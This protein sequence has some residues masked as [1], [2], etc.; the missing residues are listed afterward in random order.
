[1]EPAT[2]ARIVTPIDAATAADDGGGFTSITKETAKNQNQGKGAPKIPPEPQPPNIPTKIDPI[3]ALQEAIDA[4]SLSMFESLRSLRDAVAP[5]SGNLGVSP[6]NA[7]TTN[8]QQQSHLD[9]DELWH[10]Y[11]KGDVKVREMMH[12]GDTNPT[13]VT[14]RKEF[15][16][17]HARMEMQKDTELVFSLANDVL[18]KS[19][20]I[21][22]HVD[23]HLSDMMK[24]TRTQQM[25]RI[26]TLVEENNLVQQELQSMYEKARER[27]SQCR[28]AILS[29]TSQVLDIEEE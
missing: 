26:A 29:K 21:D 1:M 12:K 10:A 16:R 11:R 7:D 14:D 13:I 6:R 8:E 17:L 20:M 18:T 2:S 5:E 15:L 9:S 27:R 19:T 25:E 4:L 24:Y 28:Q 23:T 22:T 3:T